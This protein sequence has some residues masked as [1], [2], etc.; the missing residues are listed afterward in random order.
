MTGLVFHRSSLDHAAPGHPECPERAL[1]IL[2]G[3]KGLPLDAVD[4]RPATD[5]DLLLVHTPEHVRRIRSLGAGWI[6]A[7]TYMNFESLES[8]LW[9]AGGVLAACD[10]VVDGVV[11]NAFCV[12]RPPGHHATPSRAMGFCLFNNVAIAARH[13]QRRRGLK[14]ILIVDW[15][16]HHGN[17]T[18]EAFYDDATVTYVSTH[19]FPFYPG[20]GAASENRPGTINLPI[21]FG[22]PRDLFLEIFEAG[23][24]RAPRPDFTLI[25]CGFDAYENDP[26]GGLGLKVEDFAAMTKLVR[27]IAGDRIVSALEGGYDLAGL[28][29]C[30]REHVA[31]LG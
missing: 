2:G 24:R 4:P 15:D 10:A 22:T 14:Q 29:A 7:D 23:L 16:V 19:R 6:D 1:A 31:A 30:A 3:L 26:I 9:A 28:G 5:D 21:R 18:Q 11:P 13:L 25:S 27:Q 8:A 20:T 17:G 12:V